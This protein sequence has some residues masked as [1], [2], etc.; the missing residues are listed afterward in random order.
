MPTTHAHWS[1]HFSS[2]PDAQTRSDH[3]GEGEWQ[4][5]AALGAGNPL[6]SPFDD[7][8]ATGV[9]LLGDPPVPVTTVISLGSTSDNISQQAKWQCEV[10][11]DGT[12]QEPGAVTQLPSPCAK[13]AR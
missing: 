13:V 2:P 7:W 4:A 10:T 8:D 1:A 9:R 11:P 3:L 6:P 5:L 12:G